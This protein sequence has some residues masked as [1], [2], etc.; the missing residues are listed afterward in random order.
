MHLRQQLLELFS[1]VMGHVCDLYRSAQTLRFDLQEAAVIAQ[2]SWNFKKIWLIPSPGIVMLAKRA[3]LQQDLADR[4]RI[5]GSFFSVGF[6]SQKIILSNN[7]PFDWDL[8][9]SRNVFNE[10]KKKKT[11]TR[12]QVPDV[13]CEKLRATLVTNH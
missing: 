13:N 6:V 4:Q 12:F 10:A 11:F 7:S 8:A 5:F 9:C 1:S 2:S 3:K